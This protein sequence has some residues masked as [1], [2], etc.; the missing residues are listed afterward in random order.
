MKVYGLSSY[1][2]GEQEAEN[3]G[4]TVVLGYASL[5]EEQIREGAGRLVRAWKTGPQ[6]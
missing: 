5:T 1:F 3:Q 2:I 6:A 4:R